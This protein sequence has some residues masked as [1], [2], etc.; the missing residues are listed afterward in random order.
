MTL[1]HSDQGG[2]QGC[3]TSKSG[4]PLPPCGSGPGQVPF[5][6]GKADQLIA[7]YGGGGLIEDVFIPEYCSETGK[8]AAVGDLVQQSNNRLLR[9]TPK[10]YANATASVRDALAQVRSG[11]GAICFQNQALS[12]VAL[13]FMRA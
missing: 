2:T 9:L 10:G 7:Q 13:V 6:A 3:G 12:S 8:C 4:L 5:P 1:I 11:F